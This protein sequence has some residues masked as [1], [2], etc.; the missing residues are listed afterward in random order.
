[1]TDAINRPMLDKKVFLKIQKFNQKG[2][3]F[4]HS[5]KFID[6]IKEYQKAWNSLPEPRQLWEAGLWIKLSQAEIHL[7]LDDFSSSK[8]KLLQAMLCNGAVSNPLVHFLLGICYFELGEKASSM[9]E[10]QIAYDLEGETIFQE[11]D[12]VYQQFFFH[13]Q[14]LP[15]SSI[16]TPASKK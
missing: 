10:L 14:L 2:E 4:I 7:A 13:N 3:E 12:E 16:S 8:D 6:A 5:E 11:G 1:M 15:A 9:H